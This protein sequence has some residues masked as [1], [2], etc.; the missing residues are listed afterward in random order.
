MQINFFENNKFKKELFDKALLLYK[1]ESKISWTK[2]IVNTNMPVLAISSKNIDSIVKSIPKNLRFEFL[3]N[4]QFDYHE[5]TIVYAKVLNTLKSCQDIAKY[6]LPFAKFI[7]NWASCDT[8]S[9]NLKGKEKDD[10]FDMALKYTKSEYT[11]VRRVGFRILFKYI[12]NEYI[13]RIFDTIKETFCEKEYYVNM[14]AAWLLCEMFIK[15]R[16]K[17]F[18]FV[19]ANKLNDF[20]KNKFISKCNDS[21]RVSKEDKTMLKKLKI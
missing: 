21:Y 18:V 10:L 9:F 12:D 14:I 11:F 3:D 6:L 20:V 2:N 8:L 17:T 7:D 19:K 13:D 5:S 16:E 4:V 1:N 15:N